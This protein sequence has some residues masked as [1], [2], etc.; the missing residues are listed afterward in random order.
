MEEPQYS[1]NFLGAMFGGYTGFIAAAISMIGGSQL[2][3]SLWP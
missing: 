1:D 2:I 3:M